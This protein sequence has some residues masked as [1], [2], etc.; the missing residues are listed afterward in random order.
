[1]IGPAEE[2]FRMS[3]LRTDRRGKT[4]QGDRSSSLRL[5]GTAKRKPGYAK[6]DLAQDQWKD[7]ICNS[8]HCASID[9]AGNLIVSEWSKFGR[10]EKFVLMK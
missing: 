2:L 1:V 8:P 7:G 5:Y 4:G 9:K 6:F 3:R 10:A